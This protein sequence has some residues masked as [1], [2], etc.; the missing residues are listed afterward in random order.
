MKNMKK[1]MLIQTFLFALLML[2]LIEFVYLFHIPNPNML[3]ITV[4][5]LATA[6]GGTVPGLVC[7]ALM[8]GYSLFFFSADNSFFQFSEENLQKVFVVAMGVLFNFLGAAYLKRTRDHAVSE[9]KEAN[10]KLA[11]TNAELKK[12]NGLLEA[13]ASNDSLTNLRN[14]YSLRQDFELYVGAPLYLAFLD[15]DNFK[16]V[17]DSQGHVVGDRILASVGKALKDSFLSA[18]CYR[19]GGDEFMIVAEKVTEK[20]FLASCAQASEILKTSRI[21]FSGGYVYGTPETVSELR[22]MVMQADEMLYKS[23]EEGKNRIGGCAYDR[24]YT[25][26][27]EAV[28]HYRQSLESGGDGR[29]RKMKMQTCSA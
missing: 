1:T 22:D 28:E 18:N 6:I 8:M 27:P 5:V 12:V 29:Q 10:A 17:N 4:L 14:R 7:A 13:I 2:A 3:L 19:Y 9:L 24:S 26:G 15:L 20:E 23:K 21:S 16:D 25:P 11:K